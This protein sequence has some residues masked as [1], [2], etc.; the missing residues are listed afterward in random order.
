MWGIKPPFWRSTNGD[1]GYRFFFFFDTGYRLS[2]RKL[3]KKTKI[4]PFLVPCVSNYVQRTSFFF[5]RTS[6]SSIVL[7][8]CK[9]NRFTRIRHLI[10]TTNALHALLQVFPCHVKLLD[11][12]SRSRNKLMTTTTSKDLTKWRSTEEAKI[13]SWSTEYNLPWIFISQTFFLYIFY[14]SSLF[15][16]FA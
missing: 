8:K 14:L 4:G 7:E 12:C 9:F 13:P 1:T 10:W 5:L 3:R 15:V 11:N 2:L 16:Y 6:S